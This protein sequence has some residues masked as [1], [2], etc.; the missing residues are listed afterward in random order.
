MKRPPNSVSITSC[1]SD[2]PPPK[3]RAEDDEIKIES[4]AKMTTN[5]DI[6]SW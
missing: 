2:I 5:A 3:E 4:E 6:V 1:V